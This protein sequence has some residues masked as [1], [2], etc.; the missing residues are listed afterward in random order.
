MTGNLSVL[1]ALDGN[2]DPPRGTRVQWFPSLLVA[3]KRLTGEH[4]GL[5]H[6]QAMDL[7]ELLVSDRSPNSKPLRGCRGAGP[8]GRVNLIRDCQT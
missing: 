2:F 4:Y 3:L 8:T 5:L 6:F 7:Q 1:G